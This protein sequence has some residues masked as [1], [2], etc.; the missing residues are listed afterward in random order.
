MEINLVEFLSSCALTSTQLASTMS[1]ADI[2]IW[3][4][5]VRGLRAVW[6]NVLDLVL[7]S[8]KMF[9]HQ[10]SMRFQL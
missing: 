5:W 4:A 1:S 6:R 10:Y 8:N 2:E 3:L 9:N 7:N